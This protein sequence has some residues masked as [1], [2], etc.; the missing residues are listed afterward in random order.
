MQELKEQCSLEQKAKAHLE[1]ALRDEIDERNYKIKTLETKVGLL[2]IEHN[3]EHITNIETENGNQAE[4]LEN[5]TKYLNDA[6]K[7]IET[8]NQKLQEMK[9]NAIIFQTKEQEYKIK[10]ANFEKEITSL[11]DREKENNLKLAQSKMELH[12]ELLMKDTE[13]SNLKRESELL[14][15][16][17]NTMEAEHKNNGNMKLENLQSQN[18]KLIEKV[19]TLSQKSNNL[20]NELLKAESFKIEVENL[21]QEIMDLK[22]VNTLLTSEKETLIDNLAQSEEK[23]QAIS[24]RYQDLDQSLINE[25]KALE[26]Q[27]A[28]LRDEA[29]KGLLS[30]E[31]KI[32]EKLQN[33]FAQKEF[34]LKQE[35]EN[36]IEEISGNNA[37]LK[38]VKLQLLLKNDII[39]NMSEELEAF[40]E[41]LSKKSGDYNT[42]ETNHLELIDDCTKLRN[43]ISTL[44]KE[45]TS[46]ESCEEKV[47]RLEAHINTLQEELRECQDLIQKKEVNIIELSKEM[48]EFQNTIKQY[49]E[50]LKILEEKDIAANLEITESRLLE[51]RV[52]KLE[53][54]K[55]AL[56]EDFEKERIVLNEMLHDHKDLRAKEEEIAKLQETLKYSHEEIDSLKN[57]LKSE[58]EK[59][60]RL[61]E[62]KL[63]LEKEIDKLHETVRIYEE[64]DEAIN[65][66]NT[67]CSL[68]QLKL[69]KLEEEHKN[70]L[71]SFEMERDTLTKDLRNIKR[72]LS[73]RDEID[74]TNNENVDAET[75]WSQIIMDIR[76]LNEI[77][78]NNI[79]TLSRENT[80]L[81]HDLRKTT[82]KSRLLEEKL[83]TV[84]IESTQSK[85]LEL[86]LKKLEEENLK[87]VTEFEEE[88]K[89]FND[90]LENH[91]EL[92]EKE[93][94]IQALEDKLSK[95]LEEK[96]KLEEHITHLKADNVNI[97]EKKLNLE[98]TVSKL[99]ENVN[100]L[101]EKE[102]AIDL[103]KTECH[104]L[105]MK[106]Q[107]LEEER[108][109]LLE[110][111]EL[112]RL[113]FN[114][115]YKQLAKKEEKMK[116]LTSENLSL[117]ENITKYQNEV[118]NL[119]TLIENKDEIC[120]SLKIDA[121]NRIKEIQNQTQT[122]IVSMEELKQQNRIHIDKITEISTLN[123]E[124]T[125]QLQEKDSQITEMS[126]NITKLSN[127]FERQS[128]EY[129]R[130]H[131]RTEA[132]DVESKKNQTEFAESANSDKL[133]LTEKIDELNQLSEKLVNFEMLYAEQLD[134]NESNRQQHANL[135]DKIG[136]LQE[137]E[138]K[139]TTLLDSEEKLKGEIIKLQHS[140]QEKNK[141]ENRLCEIESEF[142]VKV[143]EIKGI[144]EENQSLAAKINELKN[145][146]EILQK[147]I[148]TSNNEMSELKLRF[149]QITLDY[150]NM[151]TENQIL[152]DAKEDL[153]FKIAETEVLKLSHEESQNKIKEENIVLKEKIE[154]I[155]NQ[156][157]DVQ[158][159]NNELILQTKDSN[160]SGLDIANIQQD[161]Y[162]IKEKCDSLF[163]ENKNLKQEYTKLEEK[164][165]E[166][167]KIKEKLQS[168]ISELEKQCTEILH[169]KQLLQDEV[170]ELKISPLNYQ[171]NSTTKL[172]QL[173]I[174]KNEQ[175]LSSTDNE[176]D[177]YEKEIESLRDKITKYKSLDLTNKSSIQFYEH[178][179]QKAKNQN[180]KLNRK[181]DETL[182]TLNHCAELSTSTEVEY[183]RN[184]LYNY[185]IGKESLVLAR[186]IA[187]VCKFDPHQTDVIL[188]REQQKQTLV[189]IPDMHVSF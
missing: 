2:Q 1:S 175:L 181:L 18:K 33:Q 74:V 30:L 27:I 35:F 32:R 109:Q 106:L 68:L 140:L 171:N 102:Q 143:D 107:K 128:E 6:R 160:S 81:I 49:Q 48:I 17:L 146:N 56:L 98:K 154:E 121:E 144:V 99:Q 36:K 93:K 136:V 11:S 87:L 31:P 185:M 166:F 59:C 15:Q 131:E 126:E 10:I 4:K 178:E 130:L 83:E 73:Q 155:T 127:N 71:D 161:F 184:V 57:S 51:M 133:L 149:Q 44:E 46:F 94:L 116:Q 167:C 52:Q 90:L 92:Q 97:Q 123:D 63:N 104:I 96:Y 164:C 45:R 67:E 85:L 153:E 176:K 78:E 101:E 29:R 120:E 91:K 157:K 65:L 75:N 103:D 152:T 174:L 95:S 41:E 134:I 80:K 69:Q 158:R 150:Q 125:K 12:N 183:L 111:F 137:I 169:E 21:K 60:V 82:E 139:Y 168:Q 77:K 105:A 173:E 119:Q 70:L 9:A 186:V 165:N 177:V 5:L 110:T 13:I 64:K 16:N 62:Q 113:S 86:K 39:K 162:E 145:K 141:L 8:L 180:D 115:T 187:A 66:D 124:L 163:I 148:D 24:V 58:R 84:E 156:L 182:V 14:K 72:S 76:E 117:K 7:E 122:L 34:E 47:P 37:G 189:S 19:E 188:Q 118:K 79:I 142:K 179:L 25:R 100:I 159:Q 38:E 89:M 43:T 55:H 170:Q 129:K 23:Y 42:L 50:K 53:E 135:Q 26:N 132:L 40:K 138:L 172:D 88:R 3:S 61:S 151:I 108:K 147:Q 28:N 54:E 114:K 20:E 112:E 22:N